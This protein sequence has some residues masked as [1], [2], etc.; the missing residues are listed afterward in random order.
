MV[1]RGKGGQKLKG[2]IK[3]L[4]AAATEGARK[5]RK[6]QMHEERQR[7]GLRARE[8][9]VARTWSG[10]ISCPSL[11]SGSLHSSEFLSTGILSVNKQTSFFPTG[12]K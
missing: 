10:L 5:K 11:K 7:R 1:D 9:C 4:Q 12:L 3:K 6:E 8:E 2:K